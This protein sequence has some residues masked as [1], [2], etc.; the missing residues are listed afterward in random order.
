MNRGE[1]DIEGPRPGRDWTV[2]LWTA[3]GREAA[4][5][6]GIA[7]R[8]GALLTAA[9]ALAGTDVLLPK[10]ARAHIEGYDW[11]RHR[12]V[13]LWIGDAPPCPPE[14]PPIREPL[15]PAAAPVRPRGRWPWSR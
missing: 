2:T 13:S 1:P 11:R 4:R 14:A 5:I 9:R 12:P 8:D 10:C 3:D 6:T 15:P 7:K